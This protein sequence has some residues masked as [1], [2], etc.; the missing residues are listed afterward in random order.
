MHLPSPLTRLE[1]LRRAHEVHTRELQ[2]YVD[3]TARWVAEQG[4]TV[5]AATRVHAAVLLAEDAERD[6]AAAAS[7]A[8][9]DAPEHVRDLLRSASTPWLAR[10]ALDASLEGLEALKELNARGLAAQDAVSSVSR[11]EH[12]FAIRSTG[13]QVG[14]RARMARLV[15]HYLPAA[16]SRAGVAHPGRSSVPPLS[17]SA[18][19]RLHRRRQSADQIAADADELEHL[20]RE[21][22]VLDGDMDDLMGRASANGGAPLPDECDEDEDGLLPFDAGSPTVAGE[23]CTHGLPEPSHQDAAEDAHGDLWGPSNVHDP[24]V[25]SGMP[26]QYDVREVMGAKEADEV[27][28]EVQQVV[29]SGDALSVSLSASWMQITDSILQP[30]GMERILTGDWLNSEAIDVYLTLVA[31]YQPT[32]MWAVQSPYFMEKLLD[33]DTGPEETHLRW[34]KCGVCNLRRPALLR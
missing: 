14:G 15:L 19:E 16:R 24:L 25:F 1:R 31:S 5:A 10:A 28:K 2:Q 6:V 23:H 4:A 20:V 12:V 21:D 22:P 7:A 26:W 17:A 29:D 18:L 3:T 32:P 33:K 8:S 11:G 13:K 30:D 9:D 27:L 34:F